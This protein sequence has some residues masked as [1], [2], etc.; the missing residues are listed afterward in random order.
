[1]NAAK[2]CAGAL[3]V[4]VALAG[5]T[6]P[7]GEFSTTTNRHEEQLQ[8]WQQQMDRQPESRVRITD[9]PGVGER[10][11]LERH[12]WLKDK[13][14]SLVLGKGQT[15]ITG[16]TLAQMLRDQ[17]IQVMSTLPLDGYKY[18]GF[19]VNQ[20]DGETA[21]RLLFG[22]MGLDYE[23]S[24]E[25]QYVVIM[26]NRART[27]YVKLGERITEYQSGT[28]TG[29]I[30]SE[31]GGS[32]G[33]SSSGTTG[34]EASLGVSTG[35]DTGTGRV[36]INGDFWANLK[37][38]LSSMMK[39]CVPDAVAPSSIPTLA[40]LPGLSG[41]TG[42]PQGGP[43]GA[44]MG[45]VG[46]AP[47]A[48][49]N[50]TYCT[51]QVM[52]TVTVNPSTGAVTVQ[53]PHWIA[54]AVEKYIEGV[55][56]DNSVTL[57]YEGMLIAVTSS[58]QRQEGI[59]LQG[60]ASFANG[61]LGMTITNNALGGVTV[62]G[63]QAVPGTEAVAGTMLGVQKLA[64]N[65]AQAFLAYLE[66]N[67]EFSIMQR[68]LVAV[69]NGVPG[70]F[71]QYD[72]LFYNQISQQASASTGDGA[73][74][75][76]TNELVPFK[77]GNLLRIVPYYDAETGYVRSPITFSQS[78]QTGTY[79]SIQ[80]IT[81]ADGS[82]QNIPSEIPL[83]RDSNYS[84]EVMMRDGDMMIIGGQISEQGDSSGSGIPGFN[85]R[86]NPL[87]ALMGQKRHSDSRSTYYLALTLKVRKQ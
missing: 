43:F 4:A 5:C 78:V 56:D 81:G 64:G 72:T 84:G 30:G 16:H 15:G 13:R 32:G 12:R 38:E 62:S 58:K 10:I 1:M 80:F 22:P 23:I 75:G 37:E 11:N 42:M 67:S 20:V 73:V 2:H 77:V 53:A 87:S 50:S 55:K 26:P 40:N 46:Q 19:G 54:D 82:I 33:S 3:V 52:G 7:T 36:S 61:E 76:T 17:G 66:A 6:T 69:T 41:V 63:G 51:E 86:N 49:G 83:I 14:V 71:G 28:M 47:A 59:D 74:V 9:V 39:Q 21:I 65:P 57:V 34:S 25:G 85:A 8:A 31:G 24:D 29:N 70:E 27:F 48:A 44:Q 68:P 18:N 35:L 79:E 45:Q 60:F